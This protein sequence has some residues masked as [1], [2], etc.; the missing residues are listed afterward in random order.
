VDVEVS[1][2]LVFTDAKTGKRNCCTFEERR[3]LPEGVEMTGSTISRLHD[4]L[5]EA[6]KEAAAEFGWNQ[7]G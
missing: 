1:V 7:G 3:E 5:R 2:G 4:L 6:M